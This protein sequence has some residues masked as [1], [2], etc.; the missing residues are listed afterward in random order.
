MKKKCGLWQAITVSKVAHMLF[1]KVD[2]IRYRHRGIGIQVCAHVAQTFRLG[3]LSVNCI[4]LDVSPRC[5]NPVFGQVCKGRKCR[6]PRRAMV[7]L[8][9]ACEFISIF[10][11]FFCCTAAATYLVVVVCEHLPVVVPGHF[12]LM[13]EMVLVHVKLQQPWLKVDCSK[14]LF[15][16]NRGCIVCVKVYPDEAQVI[17]MHMHAV[18]PIVFLVERR[19]F[20]IFRCLG[21]VAVKTIRPAL[22]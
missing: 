14:V 12:P 5:L 2:Y 20:L 18:Q 7:T 19:N 3:V 21:Q 9:C 16:R 10:F 1:A 4:V 17:D 8:F 13:I 11:A 22:T 15:P 6:M